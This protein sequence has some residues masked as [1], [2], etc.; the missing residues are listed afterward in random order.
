MAATALRG[1]TKKAFL[2]R[3]RPVVSLVKEEDQDEGVPQAPAPPESPS[4][5]VASTALTILAILLLGFVVQL[6]VISRIQHYRSQRLEYATFRNQLAQGIAP[7]GNVANNGKPVKLGDPVALLEISRIGVREVVGQG[8]TAGI[9]MS[10]PG[11]RRDTVMPGEAGA[12]VIMGRRA[13]YGGPFARLSALHVG[14]VI[15]VTTGEGISR[16]SVID[17]RRAGDEEPAALQPGEGRLV[18]TTATGAAYVP[19]GVLRVDA[20]LTSSVQPSNGVALSPSQLPA[21]EKVLAGEP[22]A[23]LPIALWAQALL[24][25][26]VGIVWARARW[27][28]WQAWLV[29]LPLLVAVALAIGDNVIRL[30]PNLT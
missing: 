3:E 8:T 24:A 28:Y 14:D 20:K 22:G 13:A 29:G 7:V 5:A 21:D 10:G 4:L 2:E 18:L 6:V 23:W 15:K 27:G 11:H 26:S 1:S 17:L 25:I 19:G 30:L 16:Y 9:L 12:S